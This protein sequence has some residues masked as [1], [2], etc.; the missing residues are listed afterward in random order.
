MLNDIETIIWKEFKEII[1]GSS[2]STAGGFLRM[3]VPVLLAGVLLPSR[4]GPSYLSG[5]G[6]LFGLAWI[7]PMVGIAI[8]VDSFAGE[9]ERHTLETLL[10]SRLSDE[11]ILLGK[12]AASVLYAWILMLASLLLAVITVNVVHR[13]GTVLMFSASYGFGLMT[14]GLLLA[15]LVCTVAI[16]VSLR[17]ATVRQASQTLGFGMMGVYFAAIFGVQAL[18]ESYRLA[19]A[20]IIL[21]QNAFAVIAGMVGLLVAIDLALI[22]AAHA[23]FKR[24]RLILD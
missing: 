21:G 10:A 19:G 12:L 6:P 13:P 20:R 14:L 16:L 22:A 3:A 5:P 9:R 17:A 1:R 2:K 24:A 8:T 7:L 4:F 15:T 23:R 18:P 11:A